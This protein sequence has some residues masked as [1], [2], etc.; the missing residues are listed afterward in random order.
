MEHY[1]DGQ[2]LD[3]TT[4][5]ER[6]TTVG[7]DASATLALLHPTVSRKH[8]ALVHDGDRGLFLVG[9]ESQYG[10]TVD[11]VRCAPGTPTRLRDGATVRFALSSR[12]YVARLA[13]GDDASTAEARLAGLPTA[14]SGG[15][16]F[17]LFPKSLIRR[18]FNQCE[19]AGRPVVVYMHPRD[20][21]LGTPHVEMSRARRFKCYVGIKKA[22]A[23]FEWMLDNWRFTSCAN[24]LSSLD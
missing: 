23:K 12:S 19:A 13:E 6:V 15:G 24:I 2:L 20:F 21:A 17:R 18:G 11:G 22:R 1:K 16:F 4:L 8:G 3:A 5:K 9:F 14:F 10:S 7:R